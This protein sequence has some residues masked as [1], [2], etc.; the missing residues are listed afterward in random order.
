MKRAGDPDEPGEDLA[1]ERREFGMATWQ[2]PLIF[3]L[4]LPG[5]PEFEAPGDPGGPSLDE[6]VARERPPV[7]T[8]FTEGALQEHAKHLKPKP[9]QEAG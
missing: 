9:E 6:L 3:H 4:P 5:A 7:T 2:S 1:A 8:H